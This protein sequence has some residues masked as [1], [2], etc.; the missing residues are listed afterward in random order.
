MSVS[1]SAGTSIRYDTPMNSTI[2]SLSTDKVKASRDR[3]GLLFQDINAEMLEQR[4]MNVDIENR[5]FNH[6][7]HLDGL[8]ARIEMM[9]FSLNKVLSKGPIVD[10]KTRNLKIISEGARETRKLLASFEEML[11]KEE[12]ICQ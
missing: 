3:R 6:R 12:A 8:D 2:K 7:E 10:S 5:L 11:D 4:E 9:F 1:V